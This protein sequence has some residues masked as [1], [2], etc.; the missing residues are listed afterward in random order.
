MRQDRFYNWSYFCRGLIPRKMRYA[1]SNTKRRRESRKTHPN[2]CLAVS[3]TEAETSRKCLF[4]FTHPPISVMNCILIAEST[5]IS[6]SVHC[7]LIKI[8]SYVKQ[9]KMV[10]FTARIRRMTGGYIF[11]LCVSPHPGGGEGTPSS[12]GGY[13]LPRS[14]G[15]TPSSWWDVPQQ[16]VPPPEQ[17]S[18]YLLRGGRYASCVQAGGLSCSVITFVYECISIWNF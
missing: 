12:W 14:R 1:L 6:Y 15:G 17:H 4:G 13:P 7:S 2:N 10:F 3:G 8:F 18:V 9:M 16:G 5:C 11:S